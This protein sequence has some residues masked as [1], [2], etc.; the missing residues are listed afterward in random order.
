MLRAITSP[1]YGRIFDRDVVAFVE[2]IVEV[3]NSRFY[4]PRDWSGRPSG[5]Y[6]SDRD[7]FCFMIDGGSIVDGGCERDQLHRGFF[8]WNSE[9]AA[10]V[11]GV[12][13]FL[14][15]YV[16]GNHIVWHAE[17]VEEIRI[18]HS[19]GAPLRFVTEAV[20]RLRA[21]IDAS[22]RPVEAAIRK[23]K[24]LLLP[25]TADGLLE[26]GQSHDFTKP[27]TREAVSK[28]L[29]EEGDCRT[30]WQFVNGVTAM[31][32]DL[33]HLDARV[34]LDRKAGALLTSLV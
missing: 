3:T 25:A 11:F 31:A 20:P 24:D 23:A 26:W 16:C 19:S 6:A 2:R 1:K 17:N 4:N 14:F 18:R 10:S 12:S 22:P 5:L 8:C 34:V 33:P 13:L 32:R 29:A 9:V 30:L 21:Y 28:A 7:V 27:E 15:R